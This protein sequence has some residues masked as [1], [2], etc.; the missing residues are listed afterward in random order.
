MHQVYN[1]TQINFLQRNP[2]IIWVVPTHLVTEK[3]P[4]V[5]CLTVGKELPLPDSPW[6]AEFVPHSSVTTFKSA[7][8]GLDPKSPSSESQQSL[9]HKANW[10]P[11][12]CIFKKFY[13]YI[14]FCLYWICLASCE[15][16]LV[17]ES[18][19]YSWVVHGHLIAMASLVAEQG[20]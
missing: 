18:R 8:E 3:I 5:Q 2:E 6:G 9:L 11:S 12:S 13:L 19:G 17:A 14:Y 15:L 1:Y 10:L 16:S 4:L 20:L 7:T